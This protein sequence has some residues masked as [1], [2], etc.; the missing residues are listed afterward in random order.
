MWRNIVEAVGLLTVVVGI[1]MVFV[2]A[3]VIVTGVI[4]VAASNVGRDA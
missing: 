2:P 1:G 3:A 4:L